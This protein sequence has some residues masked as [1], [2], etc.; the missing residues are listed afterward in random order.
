MENGGIFEHAYRNKY[1]KETRVGSSHDCGRVSRGSK[2]TANPN[3]NF[4]TNPNVSYINSVVNVGH[5]EF[6][7]AGRSGERPEYVVGRISLKKTDRDK[8]FM[9]SML[10]V[11]EKMRRLKG[12]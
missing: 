10:M 1:R 5:V 3:S 6:G 9:R 7:S 11:K 12:H 2:S 8:G 4:T